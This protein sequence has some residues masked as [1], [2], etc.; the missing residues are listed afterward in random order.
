MIVSIYNPSDIQE[1]KQLFINTFS[2][3]EGRSEGVLIGKLVGDL[4]TTTN[5]NDLHA[6]VASEN[7]QIIGGIFSRLAFESSIDAFIL[8]PVAVQTSYQ[9][10]GVGQELINYGLAALK[11]NGVEL[12]FTYG[13]PDYY[14]KVGFSPIS[15]KMAKA[16]LALSYP[17][18]WLAQPLTGAKMEPMCG[19]S[20]C[21]DALNNPELW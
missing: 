3:S 16:P 17:N 9:R 7:G 19:N 14:T 21:V 8:S 18:G 1:L 5:S 11:E 6:F 10:K 20:R 13:D 4:L 15:E 12:A 2:D